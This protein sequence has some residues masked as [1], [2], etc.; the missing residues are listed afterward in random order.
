VY[1][2]EV[3]CGIEYQVAGHLIYEGLVDEGLSI[4]KGLRGR[5]D[6][7]RRNPW[8]EFECGSHYARSLASWSLV[9]ALSGVAY[10]QGWLSFAPRITHD[11]AFACF[12][13]V[14]APGAVTR[15]GRHPLGVPYGH[16]TEQA[17]S[18]R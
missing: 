5:H 18:V 4:I 14:D 6:G 15:G 10:G 1:S 13:S 7:A 17:V 12:W 9:T 11:G 3:W 2:D 8:N 16:S